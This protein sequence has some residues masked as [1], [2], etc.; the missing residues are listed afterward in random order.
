MSWAQVGS[1]QSDKLCVGTFARLLRKTLQSRTNSV[2]RCTHR[3][4]LHTN[5]TNHTKRL[6]P[7]TCSFSLS[8]G[9]YGLYAFYQ[10]FVPWFVRF[11]QFVQTPSEKT[12]IRAV[13][14][15]G[16]S[17]KVSTPFKTIPARETIAEL[18]LF[19]QH[20]ATRRHA[21]KDARHTIWTVFVLPRPWVQGCHAQIQSLSPSPEIRSDRFGIITTKVCKMMIAES[22]EGTN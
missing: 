21:N 8:H 2:N 22:V 1:P 19:E 10:R 12:E 6:E 17:R 3:C 4:Y 15:I 13:T 18:K 16:E 14:T 20:T 11:A 5:R 7:H 9:L